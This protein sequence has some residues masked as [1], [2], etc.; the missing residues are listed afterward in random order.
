MIA[1]D[2][3]ILEEMSFNDFCDEVILELPWFMQT[4]KFIIQ[5]LKDVPINGT[6]EVLSKGSEH[7]IRIVFNSKGSIRADFGKF[8]QTIFNDEF[9]NNHWLFITVC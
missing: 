3:E 9:K 1:A 2:P 5:F 7:E 4:K 8:R 6:S